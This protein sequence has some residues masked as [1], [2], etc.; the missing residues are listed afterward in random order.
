MG[1]RANILIKDG[2]S[3]VYL[4]T[5]WCGTELPKTLQT[6][7]ARKLRWD[8]GQ[9]L[10]RIIFSEMIKD[11]LTD[12]CG[13]GISSVVGDGDSRILEVNIQKQTVKVITKTISTYTF[14]EYLALKEPK[15]E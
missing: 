11:S 2:T 5:H 7:L 3:K 15:W 8:D 9:Y 10:A 4:Y 1:D 14:K 6:A 13:Y 12:E